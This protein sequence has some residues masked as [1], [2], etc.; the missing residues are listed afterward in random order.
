MH[1]GSVG[2]VQPYPPSKI[3]IFVPDTEDLKI[4]S[5]GSVGACCSLSQPL[6]TKTVQ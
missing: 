6:G 1:T 3:I 2:A 5:H 4:Q